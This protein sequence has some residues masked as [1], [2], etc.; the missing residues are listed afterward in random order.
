MRMLKRG[1]EPK[2]GGGDHNPERG[3]GERHALNVDERQAAM[4]ARWIGVVYRR[5]TMPEMSGYIGNT[6]GVKA[7]PIPMSSAHNA[8]NGRSQS[9]LSSADPSQ[10]KA[11]A[12]G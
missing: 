10:W 11:A 6:H 4:R 12:A 9:A 1:L 3:V 2:S 7:M 8:E 5:A